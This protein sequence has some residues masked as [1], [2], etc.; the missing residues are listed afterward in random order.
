MKRVNIQRKLLI[1]QCATPNGCWWIY[2]S[3]ILNYYLSILFPYFLS[4]I[5]CS[6]LFISF[7]DLPILFISNYLLHVMI[8]IYVPFW[9]IAPISLTYYPLSNSIDLMPLESYPFV[10]YFMDITFIHSPIY[11][12]INTRI[13]CN[14]LTA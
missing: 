4:F 14:S 11:N 6:L 7:I 9:D 10:L 5:Y 3:I 13:Y 2:F 1:N 8:I 12:K